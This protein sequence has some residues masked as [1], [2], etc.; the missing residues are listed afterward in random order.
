MAKYQK[1]SLKLKKNHTWTAKPGHSVLVL[2]RGAVRFNI[3]S[4]WVVEPDADSMKIYDRK[5]PDDDCRLEVS[6]LRLA[7][8]D[9]SAL[10]V[11][12]LVEAATDEDERPIHTRGPVQSVR[13]GSMD[14]AWR[15]M[16]FVD[17]VEQ[18]EA[19]SRLCIA[20]KGVI[21]ALVTFEYWASDGSRGRSVWNTVLDTIEL[22]DYISDPT[23]GP[24]GRDS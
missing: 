14:L 5:P 16:Q 24:W 13:R 4:K 11:T 6:Y 3:P 15:E 1:T 17:P 10:P 23:Q 19:F 12:Q 7:P 9:W 22:N 8:I 21:Q 2:D 18:R 20:R